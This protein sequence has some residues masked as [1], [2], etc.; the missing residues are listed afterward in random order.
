MPISNAINAPLIQSFYTEGT[1]K[2]IGQI[3]Q[4]GVYKRS[5]EI[6]NVE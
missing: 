6:P 1:F 4:Q 2:P 3:K 5:I